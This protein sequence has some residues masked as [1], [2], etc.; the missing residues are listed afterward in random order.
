ML[1]RVRC[2]AEILGILLEL[3]YDRLPEEYAGF[4]HH[5]Q[6]ATVEVRLGSGEVYR[7]QGMVAGLSS[8][9]PAEAIFRE[10]GLRVR[11]SV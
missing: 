5:N 2:V 8:F 1:R 4:F 3:Y 10:R 7:L 9:L 6:S 11:I